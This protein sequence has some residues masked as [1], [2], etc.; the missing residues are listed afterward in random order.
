MKNTIQ[1]LG[2][3]ALVFSLFFLSLDYKGSIETQRYS[4]DVFGEQSESKPQLSDGHSHLAKEG[5]AG[6]RYTETE[7]TDQEKIPTNSGSA[8]LISSQLRLLKY[9]F[10]TG[11]SAE[12]FFVQKDITI[13]YRNLRI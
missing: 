9:S 10:Q 12:G 4:F 13:F 3:L 1:G 2:I 6:R 8:P 5:L 7:V 11:L